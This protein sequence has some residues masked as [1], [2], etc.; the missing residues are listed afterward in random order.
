MIQLTHPFITEEQFADAF[1]VLEECK[2]PPGLGFINPYM[3]PGGQYGNCWWERDTSLALSGYCWLDQQFSENALINFTYVQK[4]NGRIPLWGGDRVGD[5]DEQLSAIPVIFDVCRRICRRTTDR[6]YIERIYKML[7]AYLDWW[8]SPVK[9]DAAT[10]LV[11]AIFEESDPSDYHEQLTYAPV[12]LNVQVC[13]GADVLCEL[14]EYLGYEQDVLR[15]RALFYELRDIINTHLWDEASGAYYT[16]NVK[17]GELMTWRPYNST[18]DTFKRGIA[19]PAHHEKMLAVLKNNDKYGYYNPYGITTAPKD[20]PEYCETT[21]I[22]QGWTSW[23]GNVWTLR[24]EIIARGLHESGLHAEAAHVAHQTVMTFN[25]NYAEF[26]SPSTGQGHGVLRYA[27]TASQYI[28]LLVEEI[29]GIDWCAWTNTLT[30]TPNIPEAL[31]G[32]TIAIENLSLGNG[33]FVHVTV[34]CAQNP[35]VSYEITDGEKQK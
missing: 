30:V 11:C 32:H 16:R 20:S 8:L 4:P 13:V 31:Y 7:A 15:Y 35:A 33:K 21:G 34:K 17:T 27:W 29:F 2:N 14:A 18:F 5:F 10:G 24:N 9:R 23:S 19:S 1:A 26:A 25:G 22:Y 12:D 3:G 28:E 6:A